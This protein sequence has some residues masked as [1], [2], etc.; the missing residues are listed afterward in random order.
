MWRMQLDFPLRS[1]LK[2]RSYAKNEQMAAW[3]LAEAFQ[4]LSNTSA[5]DPQQS[6]QFGSRCDLTCIKQGL[7]ISCSLHAIRTSLLVFAFGR[8]NGRNG[9]PRVEFGVWGST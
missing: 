8:R 6:G 7:V 2:I 4:D 3:H 9:I 1:G 5:A